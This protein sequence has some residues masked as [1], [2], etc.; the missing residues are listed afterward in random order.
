MKWRGRSGSGNV[1]DRR[2]MGRTGAGLGIGTI[3]IVIIAWLT[4]ADP[5]QLLQQV[6][7]TNTEQPAPGVTS[8]SDEAAQFVAVVL[9]ETEVVWDDVFRNQLNAQYVQPKL[10]LFTAEV[11]SA[12]G[13][14]S[15][16]SGPFY[17][18][19]SRDYGV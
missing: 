16:A 1:E 15:A 3:I 18:P 9:K 11:Q 19:K 6:N 4:G 14:A 5:S 12:C 10:V 2:G 17:C 7:V 8:Q 13:F